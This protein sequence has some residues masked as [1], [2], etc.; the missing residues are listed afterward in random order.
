MLRTLLLVLVAANLLFFAFT[1]GGFD[2]FMGLS[3]LG[4]R[5]P[6]RLARQVRPDS[7][8]LLPM[9]ATASAVGVSGACFEA[10]P[11]NAAEAALVEGLLRAALP[12]GSWADV[13]SDSVTAAGPATSHVYRVAAADPALAA[14]L[15][16]VRLDPSGRSFSPCA[17][18]PERPR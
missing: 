5:E 13:R 8:R 11:F 4:D 3:S 9:A 18:R 7:I 10:G 16:G 2:G 1:R 14:R 17:P 6:E 12:P 15:P